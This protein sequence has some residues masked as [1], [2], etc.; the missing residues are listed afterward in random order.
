MHLDRDTPRLSRRHVLRGL[1]VSLSLPL[2][3]CMQPARAALAEASRPRRCAFMYLPNGVN[4]RAWEM[5]EVGPTYTMSRLLE[6]LKEQRDVIT[7]ISGL[8]H[9]NAIGIN[10]SAAGMWLTSGKVGQSDKNTISVD[11]LVARVTAPQTRF[12][13]LELTCEGHGL[14]VNADGIGLPADAN[15]GVVFRRL[16]EEPKGG[17]A[18]QRRQL[19]RRG[20]ILDAVLDEATSLARALGSEDRGR[21]DQ[22]L[23]A[24]REVEVRTQRADAWLDKPRPKIEEA[25]QS[26]LN[27]DVAREMLGEYYRTMYDIIVLAFQTDMTRVATFSTGNEGVGPAVPEIGIK[28]TRHSL[29]HHNGNPVLLEELAQSDVFNIRQF[30]YFLKRL[31]EVRDAQGPL[32]DTTVAVF[33]SAMS[34]GHGHG[35]TSVPT[36]LA[37]GTALGFKH[38]SHVD[39]NL[40][41]D[42]KGYGKHPGMYFGPVNPKAHLSNLLLT[43]AQKMG[44]E[45]E[46][47]GDSGGVVSEVLS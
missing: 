29:S 36:I 10:H 17:I 39:Y 41:K 20:S 42:F 33:G 11:Q 45:T 34:E 35:M 19:G 13:S 5:A 27:R 12:S 38:G 23:V 18:A 37:G 14:A 44:V 25:V 1:G 31:G 40:V 26:K 16:F 6:P 47:F 9:P 28:Q 21:L 7:P 43:V 46:V 24:V 3:D 15:P 2:L 4:T 22:Y 8:Y 32:L 30:G